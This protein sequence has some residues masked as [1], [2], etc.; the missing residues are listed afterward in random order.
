MHGLTTCL[1]LLSFASLDAVSTATW[2]QPGVVREHCSGV[3]NAAGV[4]EDEAALLQTGAFKPRSDVH[5]SYGSK[6]GGYRPSGQDKYG[7]PGPRG[8]DNH[9]GADKLDGYTY[10]E[11]SQKKSKDYEQGDAYMP[12]KKD[13]YY[14]SHGQNQGSTY[15]DYAHQKSKDYEDEAAFLQA[16]VLK[17]RSDVA[18]SY[19]SKSGKYRPPGHNEYGKSGSRGHDNRY[20]ADR[21]DGYTYVE[22]AQ[23]KTEDYEED[24]TYMA[25]KK[26]DNYEYYGKNHGYTY[27]NDYE[28][29]RG[30][31]WR[32]F[33]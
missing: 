28:E 8:H 2:A 21:L 12:Y 6:Y 30:R 3:L 31:R 18:D 17:P 13:N 4:N 33:S 9:Y 11:Y 5:D 10:G 15:G 24:D 7:K 20:G 16:D 23:K 32:L 29:G 26:D 25:Y 22:Y 27:G 1:A 19:G 14:D